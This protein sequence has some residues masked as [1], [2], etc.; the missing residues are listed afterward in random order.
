VI[1]SAQFKA[2][3]Q[4]LELK[5]QLTDK[6]EKTMLDP[7]DIVE[8]MGSG[9]N[10]I[11]QKYPQSSYHFSPNFI[12]VVLPYA[13][14]FVESQKSTNCRSGFSPSNNITMQATM[15]AAPQA[16]E[17][18]K[19]CKKAKTRNEIQ[20]HLGLKNRD[21]FRKNILLPLINSG[22][23]LLTLPEKPTS[24]KQKFYTAQVGSVEGEG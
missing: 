8:Q 21:H 24:P 4:H 1:K 19:F 18:L 5:A 15:Q 17:V 11:L 16:K 2:E 12:R 10:R 13:D 14:G 23:L 9:I 20:Q 22:Q 6:L 3:S 7:V